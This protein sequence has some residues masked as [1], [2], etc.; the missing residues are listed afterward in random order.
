MEDLQDA[1]SWQELQEQTFADTELSN[2]K[3]A[4][5]RIFE[6]FTTRERHLHR[7]Q[8]DSIFTET[9]GVGGLIVRGA[10]IVV[11]KSL[12]EKVV[13]LAHDHEGY[14]GITKIKEYLRTRVWFPG[15]D[16][17]REAHIQHCHS[18]QIV[19]AS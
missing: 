12:R 17:K 15:L 11:P 6:Y 18:C 3:E 9:A 14:Q 4:I 5:A 13:R 2:L 19:S 1:V 7:P 10:G 8:Y 16:K